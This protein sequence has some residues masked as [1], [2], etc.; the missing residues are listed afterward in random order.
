VWKPDGFE[1][2]VSG[3]IADER[4][5]LEGRPSR[6]SRRFPETGKRV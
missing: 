4:V 1:V 2:N 6:D 3:I 5:L